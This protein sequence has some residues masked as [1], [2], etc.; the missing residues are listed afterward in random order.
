[1]STHLDLTWGTGRSLSLGKRSGYGARC[2]G[3]RSQPLPR[4]TQG[5]IR[6][7][8]VLKL[9]HFDAGSRQLP[10][11][12]ILD[13]MNADPEPPHRPDLTPATIA[14][15]ELKRLFDDPEF[16]AK[17]LGKVTARLMGGL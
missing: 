17:L 10:S 14:Q 11:V 5:D 3:R 9:C 8:I 15:A 1:M 16:C 7:K 4:R 12:M 2:H 13:P 6:A